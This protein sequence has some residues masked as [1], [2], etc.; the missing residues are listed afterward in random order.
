MMPFYIDEAH[1]AGGKEARPLFPNPCRSS[2]DPRKCQ[3][4][5]RAT[6]S[7]LRFE[8]FDSFIERYHAV[9]SDRGVSD[10]DIGCRLGEDKV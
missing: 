3:H 8:E 2:K 4:Q 6:V 9:R 1:V 7:I 5:D 10:C